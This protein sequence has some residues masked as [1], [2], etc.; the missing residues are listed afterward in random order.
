MIKKKPFRRIFTYYSSLKTEMK[1]F[2]SHN[3]FCYF[4]S[5]KKVA[6]RANIQLNMF[7]NHKKNQ[8]CVHGLKYT[9]CD[10]YFFLA[11][12]ITNIVLGSFIASS[13]SG[14]TKNKQN[15]IM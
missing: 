15:H 11:K 14:S 9:L 4:Y 10:F 7:R 13:S 2:K 5:L 3:D 6:T 12:M 1:S 8:K